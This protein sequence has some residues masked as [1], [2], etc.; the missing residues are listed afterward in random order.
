VPVHSNERLGHVPETCCRW[1]CQ[2][3]PPTDE[4]TEKQEKICC[5]CC[6]AVSSSVGTARSS[7]LDTRQV[8]DFSSSNYECGTRKH[9]T[10]SSTCT[11]GS[12]VKPT[13]AER[14]A[15][16]TLA[17]CVLL[18]LLLLFCCWRS[19]AVDVLHQW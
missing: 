18:L 1:Y 6:T 15:T 9:A 16:L 4:G 19:S 14:T 3:H 2:A 17:S 13:Q 11:E 8:V 10:T 12:K 7:V 5:S